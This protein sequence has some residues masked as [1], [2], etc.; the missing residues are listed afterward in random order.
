MD[1]LKKC[2]KCKTIPLKRNFNKDKTKNNG[3]NPICKVWRIGYYNEKRE[4]RK[5]YGKFY[6]RQNRARIN[7]YERQKR[8]TDSN[9]KLAHNIRAVTRQAFKSQNV[10]KTNDLIGCSQTFLRKWIIHQL[11]GD[12]TLDN[13]GTIWCLDHCYPLSKTNLS[14]ERDMY[15]STN[16]INIRPMYFSENSSKG[17]KIDHRLY[18]M[19]EIKAKYFLKLNNDQQGLN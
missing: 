9:Y 12:M 8:I 13:Y 3:L 5:E 11:Y 7:A 15:K 14:N 17:D 6:A 16:W 19:Q 10:K 1:E 18:L 2:S 4:Q